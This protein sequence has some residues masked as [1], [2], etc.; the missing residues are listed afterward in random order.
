M[1]NYSTTTGS[2]NGLLGS[3]LDILSPS[4]LTICAVSLIP[5]VP[6]A[7]QELLLTEEKTANQLELEREQDSVAQLSR[8]R[9]DIEGT[10]FLSY[11]L[12]ASEPHNRYPKTSVGSLRC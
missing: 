9:V 8:A 4:C 10:I 5:I 3:W 1:D 6:N 11:L 7:L 2:I 12:L